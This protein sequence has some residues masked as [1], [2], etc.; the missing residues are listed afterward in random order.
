MKNDAVKM[1]RLIAIELHS[2]PRR[3]PDV[4]HIYIGLTKLSVDE[5]FNELS[6]GKGHEALQGKWLAPCQYVLQS[7]D[8]FAD[9]KMAKQ[10]L[11]QEKLRLARMGYGVNGS[12]TVWHGYVVDLD[13]T[14]MT[15]I[16]KGYV[17]VG[18]TSHTPEKRFEIHRGPKPESPAHDL[19]SRVVHKRGVQLNYDLMSMLTPKGPVF[20]QKDA[21]SLERA[22]AKKLHK[23]GYRVEAGDATPDR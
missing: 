23:Q 1:W 10:L 8:G 9:I 18:Q 21:I 20:T 2:L 7:G 6:G 14:G 16:G 22:W 3:L 12:A 11:R 15:E 5:R 4:P 19:R 13:S 17:Y